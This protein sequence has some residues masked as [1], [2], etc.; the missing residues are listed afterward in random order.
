MKKII[1]TVFAIA[2]SLEIALRLTGGIYYWVRTHRFYPDD[3]DKIEILC[4]GESTTFGLL[5]QKNEAYPAQLGELL[6]AK[7]PNK[8]VVYNRGVP[9]ITSSLL[10]FNIRKFMD[11][12]R[13][14]VVIVSCGANEFNQR[15]VS[16]NTLLLNYNKNTRSSAILF[17]VSR[18]LWDLKTYRLLNLLFSNQKNHFFEHYGAW[19]NCENKFGTT[20]KI[21]SEEHLTELIKEQYR[22]NLQEITRFVRLREASIVYTTYLVPMMRDVLRQEAQKNQAALCDQVEMMKKKNIAF[23][24]LVTRDGFHPNPQGHRIMAEF[25]LKTLEDSDIIKNLLDKA[26]AKTQ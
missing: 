11:E 16:T 24:A 1:F 17:Y 7:Y 5:V 6:E 12:I 20:N 23:S 8:F 18:F 26:S 13:P 19:V 3:N 10:L 25:L 9:G 4:L 22:F 21:I 15:L 2:L 14:S